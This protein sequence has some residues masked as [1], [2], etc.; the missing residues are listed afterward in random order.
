MGQTSWTLSIGGI[1]D[2]SDFR[3]KLQ[4]GRAYMIVDQAE[5]GHRFRENGGSIDVDLVAAEQEGGEVH[6]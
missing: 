1:P 5:E 2:G 3:I 6:L 4:N